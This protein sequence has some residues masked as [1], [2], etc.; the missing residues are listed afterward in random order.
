MRA[1]A[2]RNQQRIVRAARDTFDEV[3]Y[4][5]PLEQVA[6]RAGVGIATLYR[7]FGTKEELLRAVFE[8]RFREGIDPVVE[9]ALRGDD[10]WRGMVEVIEAW[11]G[12]IAQSGPSAMMAQDTVFC[13]E[14][15]AR[16][17]RP[18]E[19]LVR[20][21]QEHGQARADLV[22]GDMMRVLA[23]LGGVVFTVEKGG[24]G[25]RRYVALLLDALR[26]SAATDPLPPAA[27]FVLPG[28]WC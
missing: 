4:G 9:R 5:A 25:W 14:S 16:F 15:S 28:E 22:P 1:D 17:Y 18:L 2:A 23:M 24:D 10:A 19:E 13:D 11:A 27:P 3:G 26:P 12:M 20:R 6:A 7:R 21:A 8:L